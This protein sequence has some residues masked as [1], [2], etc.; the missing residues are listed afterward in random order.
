MQESTSK[1]GDEMSLKRI[2]AVC[3]AVLMLV[4]TL[5]L[6]TE[7]AVVGPT[8]EPN[9]RARE[10][11]Q[12]ALKI[13]QQINRRRE[14]AR[15]EP[16]KTLPA[17]DQAA[18]LRA[19]ELAES[20][21]AKRPDGSKS[22]TAY[23]GP[24]E[25]F[26]EYVYKGDDTPKIVSDH[27]IGSGDRKDILLGKKRTHIGVGVYI[28]DTLGGDDDWDFYYCLLVIRQTE[29]LEDEQEVPPLEE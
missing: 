13:A 19:K 25:N 5:A 28:P 24:W 11:Q 7:T 16:F 14:R 1:G 27:F 17:L 22:S 21:A 4:P 6:A 12:T 29:E 2:V 18:M 8:P 3:L 9:S 23:D 10:E 20:F 26:S 15:L